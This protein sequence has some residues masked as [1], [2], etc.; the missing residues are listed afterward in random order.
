MPTPV[1]STQAHFHHGYYGGR[2]YTYK[3]CLEYFPQR[4]SLIALLAGQ[5]P[6]RLD[7][8]FHLV[9]FGCGQ[10]VGLCL[11]A[12]LHPQALFTGIDV[13]PTHISHGRQLAAAAGLTNVSF[14]DADLIAL[15]AQSGAAPTTAPQPPLHP[16]PGSIDFV[17]CHGVLSWVSRE[18]Q[19]A[20][21]Q[22][23][24][25]CL[26]PGGL[27]ALSYNA[28]PGTL[29]AVP[30]QHLV[31]SLQDSHEAG[32]ASLE[33]ALQLSQ[34]L[35]QSGAGLFHAQPGLSALLEDL[36]SRDPAY[37]PHE[38]NQTHWQPRFSDAVI[39]LAAGHGFSFL[40]T[41]SLV[42]SF[43]ALLP[44][45]FRALIAEHSDP[46]QRQLLR[47]LLVNTSFRRDL[48]ARGLDR[49]WPLDSQQALGDIRILRLISAEQLECSQ[50][51]E[52]FRFDLSFGT[53]QGNPDWFGAFLRA[54]GSEPRRIADLT[55][56]E[57]I[58][59]IP[60]PELLQNL[61]L[62]LEKRLVAE[63]APPV[64]H[65][66]AQRLNR[67]LANG[68]RAGAPYRLLAAPLTGSAVALS[69]LDGLAL[70][71]HFEGHSE[72]GLVAA[73]ATNL[74][75]LGRELEQ[76]GRA[77]EG[78]EGE[79]FLRH[80]IDRFQRSTLPRLQRLGAVA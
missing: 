57:G 50:P 77:L 10:G 59:P 35:Q 46:A 73:V 69:D 58:G 75:D 41:A 25:S 40:A 15:A 22:L 76:N 21:W 51:Q 72:Q 42:E 17:V 7:Q 6:P 62:L 61:A 18:V 74:R 66:P 12:A 63:L 16:P 28:F 53:M 20:I 55:S 56:L 65:T 67:V 70:A 37:L 24:S 68:I 29:S 60:L 3:A 64:D 38:Y 9:D 54:L 31:R 13:L 78:D 34:R 43:E 1:S 49:P 4:L 27:L 45:P 14:Q 47:D 26:R 71:A 2:G 44:A 32:S 30:F 33:A 5:R 39:R 19:Q 11:Q 48:Y 79:E 23:A 8:P 52:L 36:P 80:Q